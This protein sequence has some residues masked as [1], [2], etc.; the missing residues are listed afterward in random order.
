MLWLHTAWSSFGR[1]NRQLELK[2]YNKQLFIYC[3][4]ITDFFINLCS[5]QRNLMGTY[6]YTYIYKYFKARYIFTTKDKFN[7]QI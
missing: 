2:L 7:E 1:V 4:N 3:K 6:I 5:I